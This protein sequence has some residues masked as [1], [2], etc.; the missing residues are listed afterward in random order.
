MHSA[1]GRPATTSTT[2]IIVFSLSPRR[3]KS[4]TSRKPFPVTPISLQG[5]TNRRSHADSDRG[6]HRAGGEERRRRERRERR[7]SRL[8]RNLRE[9][10]RERRRRPHGRDARVAV[11]GERRDARHRRDLRLGEHGRVRT[12]RDDGLELGEDGGDRVRLGGRDWLHD[13]GDGGD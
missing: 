7:R 2:L 10:I 5:P 9:E 11:D 8:R 1:E 4:Y 12:R 13:G 3:P 6:R